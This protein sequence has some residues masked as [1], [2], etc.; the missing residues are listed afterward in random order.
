M[1][2]GCQTAPPGASGYSG[3]NPSPPDFGST[4]GLF[5]DTASKKVKAAAH[6]DVREGPAFYAAQH[7][8]R[9]LRG[10]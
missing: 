5:A 9:L 8:Q 10:P 7:H 2:A 1:D 4:L 3:E 6:L